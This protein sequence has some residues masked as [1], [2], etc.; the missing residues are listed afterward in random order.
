VSTVP[1]SK[2]RLRVRA[3]LFIG[4][5]AFMLISPLHRALGGRSPWLRDWLLYRDIGVGLVEAQFAVVDVHGERAVD[6][7]VVLGVPRG[8]SAADLTH[9]RGEAGLHRVCR[10]LCAAL[11]PGSELRVRAR[12]AT[13]SGWAQIDD[14][15]TDRCGPT[16]PR[17]IRRDAVPR[18]LHD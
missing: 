13:T 17:P 8:R 12:I 11:G 3:G 1:A 7:F 16:G 4:I 2:A 15:Q 14:G 5:A 9:I 18:E 10:R 6:R